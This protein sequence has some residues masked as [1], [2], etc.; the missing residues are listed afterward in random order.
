METEDLTLALEPL[1]GSPSRRAQ[2]ALIDR[3]EAVEAADV[4]QA[5]QSWSV[6]D[7]TLAGSG[8]VQFY[9][10]LEE[11]KADVLKALAKVVVALRANFRTSDGD[12]DWSGRSWDYR[13]AVGEMYA[14]AGVP[15]D[16]QSNIQASLRY[17]V[18]N[19]LREAVPAQDLEAAGLRTDSPKE[20]M[21]A[22]RHAVQALAE[23]LE[24]GDRT[25]ATS[26]EA[27]L[28]QLRALQVIGSSLASQVA[29]LT[30][31]ERAAAC[32]LA[33]ACAANLTALCH[34]LE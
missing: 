26:G 25:R 11:T 24:A 1:A 17:H 6:Q 32:P 13:Q 15:P 33:I 31:E 30:P 4:T 34:L 18:G 10:R 9:A 2:R 27:V 20:R 3:L 12:V 22:A 21:N 14:S 23:T 19:L 8:L 16:S 29:R 28:K 5:L 7:L